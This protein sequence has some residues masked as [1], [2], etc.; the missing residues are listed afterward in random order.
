VLRRDARMK[1]WHGRI[2]RRAGVENRAGG[3]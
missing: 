3:G 2:K 1:A